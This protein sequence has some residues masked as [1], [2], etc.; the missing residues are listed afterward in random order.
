[1]MGNVFNYHY[2][3]LVLMSQKM[4]WAN[5]SFCVSFFLSV[6]FFCTTNVDLFCNEVSV[7]FGVLCFVFK[8][9]VILMIFVLM[10]VI[11]IRIVNIFRRNHY[12]Y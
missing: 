9:R 11:V 12:N 2:L 3:S 10:F 7:C 6:F 1:M 4:L 8:I 5:S